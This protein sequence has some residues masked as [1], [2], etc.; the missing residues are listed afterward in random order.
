[1]DVLQRKRIRRALLC[2]KAHGKPLDGAYVVDG[3]LLLKIGKGNLSILFVYLEG[4]DGGG[5]LLDQGKARIGVSFVCPVDHVFQ[6]GAAQAPGI[7]C[8]HT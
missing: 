2:V 8:G 3:A 6:R 1:M 7:P 5:N 4:R